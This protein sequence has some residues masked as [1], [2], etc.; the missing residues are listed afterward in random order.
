VKLNGHELIQIPGGFSCVGSDELDPF[1]SARERPLREVF[2]SEFLISKYP[3]TYRQYYQYCFQT[4]ITLPSGWNSVGNGNFEAV[5][6]Q[7]SDFPATYISWDM[8]MRYC[9]WLS[10]QSG[11]HFTL[12]TEAE[13]EKAAR[14]GDARIWPW[15]NTFEP[16][17][18]NSIESGRDGFCSVYEY[19]KGASPFGCH[20]MAGGVWEWCLDCYHPFGHATL[21]TVNP[22]NL[23]PARQRVVKGGSAFCTKEIV[24]PACRDWTNSVN[25]GGADDGFRIVLRTGNLWRS[26]G[27]PERTS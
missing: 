16:D 10:T 13:W 12:P 20:H 1:A 8:A 2:V 5:L 14:G 9:H 7:Y 17:Y 4:H 15:G 24:R 25:Q 21:P 6:N 23:A 26:H 18:C 19:E 22:I 11:K 27:Y 3:T